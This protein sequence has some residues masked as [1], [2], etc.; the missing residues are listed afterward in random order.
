MRI[1]SLVPSITEALFDFGLNESEIIGRTKFCIHPEDFV[2]KVQ[3]VGGTKNLNL[4]KIKSLQPD[5]IIANKE[6][7]TKEQIEELQKDFEVWVT[8]IENL[9]DN[10][11]FLLELGK[12]LNRED[13]SAK[14]IEEINNVFPPVEKNLLAAYLI[15]QNPLMTVGNDTFIYDIMEKCGIKNAFG[16]QKRYPEIDY[17]DLEKA[18]VILLSTEPFPFKQIHVEE[19]RKK[20][21]E[22]KVYLLDGEAFSWYGTHLSRRKTYFEKLRKE[23]FS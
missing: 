1:I 16:E 12:I 14:F 19:Y 21:P 6:E 10:R 9:E 20:F 4:S 8:D 13:I 17:S 7:N 3:I 23:I 5:L 11:R 15:W 18:D 2:S 22:K